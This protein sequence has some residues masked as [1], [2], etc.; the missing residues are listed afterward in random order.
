M[1]R[2]RVIS[3]AIRLAVLVALA[4]LALSLWVQPLCYRIMRQT[5]DSMRA[6]LA[7]TMVKPGQFTHPAPGLTVYAQ[8]ID[9]AAVIHNL[10]INV[11]SAKG[12]D[13]TLTA[14][15][16]H[17]TQRRGAPVL[18]LRHGANQE[19]SSAGVLNFLS[20]DEYAL[21]L[22]PLIAIDRTVRYKPSD[23]Y[24]HELFF[25]DLRQAWE[26]SNRR[27]FLAEGHSRLA[28]PLYDI[29]FMAIA[30][31]GVIGGSFSRMGYGGRIAAAAAAA[32]IA[33]TLGFAAQVAAA[34]AP[35][36]NPLQYIIP[37]IATLICTALIFGRPGRTVRP[38][39]QL[40][41]AR[42]LAA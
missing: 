29:A 42:E 40:G 2:W 23:R 6:D 25:P 16:G 7:A 31:A 1:S 36:L 14:R 33:R 19:F 35:S 26:R 5:L 21:E 10:F 24:L 12:R 22:S 41:P 17:L 3:P 34:Q 20:F 4:S 18:I 37:L 8:S 15:E 27:Q 28:A 11:A 30:L 39:A 13:T 38:P 32:L 9:D